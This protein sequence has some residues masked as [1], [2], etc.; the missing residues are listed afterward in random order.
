[1][2]EAQRRD[3]E[4]KCLERS[5]L[6]MVCDGH[7]QYYF[8]NNNINVMESTGGAIAKRGKWWGDAFSSLGQAS[9]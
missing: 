2:L 8:L 7:K 4:I 9:Y 1:M 3:L 6:M 5:L